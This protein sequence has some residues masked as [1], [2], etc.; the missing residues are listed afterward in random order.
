MRILG[1]IVETSALRKQCGKRQDG[2]QWE[3]E[4]CAV[5]IQQGRDTLYAEAL[6]ETA[7]KLVERQASN[8]VTG[9]TGWVDIAM[10]A[11]SKLTANNETFYGTDILF[12][13]FEAL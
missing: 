7:R 11:R 12:Y 8:P 2:S 4:K 13:G 10:N 6:D 9:Q 5:K 1:K 3:H